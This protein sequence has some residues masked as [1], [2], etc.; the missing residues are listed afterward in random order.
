MLT[1]GERVVF[2]TAKASAS[3]DKPAIEK[4]TAWRRGQVDFDEVPLEQAVTEM[5][6]YSSTKL[7]VASDANPTIPITGV[8]KIGAA[9]SFAVAVADEYHLRVKETRGG[10]WLEKGE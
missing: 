3:K 5:N 8:F 7:T 10:I 9:K 1:V 2:D 6:R 4:I